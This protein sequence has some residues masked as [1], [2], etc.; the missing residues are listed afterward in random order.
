MATHPK[1]RWGSF[2]DPNSKSQ[3]ANTLLKR[4]PYDI[5]AFQAREAKYIY[6]DRSKE[7]PGHEVIDVLLIPEQ[8]WVTLIHRYTANCTFV[9]GKEDYPISPHQLSESFWKSIRRVI[10]NRPGRKRLG[11]YGS[12]LGTVKRTQ[13]KQARKER[14][15]E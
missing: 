15:A 10:S 7:L 6:T 1:N 11:N 13:L 9:Q 2:T 14:N 5:L 8:V 4:Y 3:I 12:S